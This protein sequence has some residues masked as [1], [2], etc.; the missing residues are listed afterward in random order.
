MRRLRVDERRDF[1]AKPLDR[2]KGKPEHQVRVHAR[3]D[4]HGFFKRP[5]RSRPIVNAAEPFQQSIVKAL[6]PERQTIDART[7]IGFELR[8]VGRSGIR[9]HRDLRVGCDGNTRANAF[10]Q[11]RE[12]FRTHQRRRPAPEVDRLDFPTARVF[13]FPLEFFEECLNVALFGNG[14]GGVRIEVAVR[15]L[16]HAPGPVHV[17]RQRNRLGI[18]RHAQPQRLARSTAIS[19]KAAPRWLRR[20]FSSA[21]SDAAVLPQAGT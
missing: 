10:E 17:E 8:F 21:V 2:L 4:A 13:G 1:V 9:L 15:T 5:D 12:T 14:P 20:F 18:Q 11:R 19:R 7:R 3:K 16:S 6:N